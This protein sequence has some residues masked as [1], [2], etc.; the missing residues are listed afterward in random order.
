MV[1]VSVIIPAHNAMKYLPQTV[2]SVFAQTL[3]DWELL[4][5]NDGSEDEI[6]EWVLAIADPRV[7]LINQVNYGVAVARNTGIIN[8]QGEYI[9]FLD[10]DDLWQP[11]KLEKQL[12]RFA[13][14]PEA[15]LVYT[16]SAL[17]TPEGKSLNRFIISHEEGDVWQNFLLGNKIGNGSA[18]MVRRCCFDVVGRFD[19]HLSCAADRDLWIRLAAEYPFA[20]VKEPL[21]LWVQ[22]S[23]SMSKNR[24]QMMADL[25]RVLEKNFANVPPKLSYLRCQSYSQIMLRQAWNSIDAK[26]LTE[27]RSFQQA[28]Q[29]YY[30]PCRYW[31]DYLRLSFTIWMMNMFGIN[32]YDGIREL[33]RY[34]YR[35]LMVGS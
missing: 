3:S 35:W 33:T 34:A 24:L 17:V 15:G 6:V 21:T 19:P 4:I 9:A 20:V 18:A 23:D 28:A 30:P 22:H 14:C 10:A 26:K 13:E 32:N 5:V 12:A 1:Q 8:A 16:W 11:T 27:A 2:A 31:S 29:A 7:Q 25:E